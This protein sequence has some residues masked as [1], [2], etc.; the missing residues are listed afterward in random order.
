MESQWLGCRV[1]KNEF[2]FEI[3]EVR[4]IDGHERVRSGTLRTNSGGVVPVRPLAELLGLEPLGQITGPVVVLSDGVVS[5]GAQ[6]DQVFREERPETSAVFA[7]PAATEG[8]SG[9]C[10]GLTRIDGRLVPCIDAGRLHPDTNHRWHTPR[11]AIP[12]AAQVF[13]Q[14]AKRDS[15]RL[16]CFGATANDAPVKTIC[17]VSY[18]QVLEVSQDLRVVT[19][20]GL[21]ESSCL[22]GVAD[23]RDTIIPVVN[24]RQYLDLRHASAGE[25][26][27]F[28]IL[29]GIRSMDVMAVPMR[30]IRTVSLPLSNASL[31]ETS[32][33]PAIPLRGA[34]VYQGGKLLV[35]DFDGILMPQT[36]AS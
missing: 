5:F 24:I 33:D 13:D 22:L 32:M 3:S 19:V 2:C 9:I 35:P 16:L 25:E 31:R 10:Y 23:W 36:R 6:V 27:L 17:G 7:L 26:G 4:A 15:K 34:F 1:G 18:S 14:L 28:A 21:A 29:R 8:H 11:T 30:D 12:V 20:P